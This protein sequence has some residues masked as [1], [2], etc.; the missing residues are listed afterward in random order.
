MASSVSPAH[1]VRFA[2]KLPQHEMSRNVYY[3]T[4]CKCG[5]QS[6]LCK[7]EARSNQLYEQHMKRRN[8]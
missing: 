6:P 4:D 3:V 1:S 8:G 5:W 2:T 7:S